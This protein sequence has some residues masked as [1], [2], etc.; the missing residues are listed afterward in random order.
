MLA[1]LLY[2][3]TLA[4]FGF[5]IVGAAQLPDS[6]WLVI[7]IFPVF[8]AIILGFVM[9]VYAYTEF[10]LTVGVASLLLPIVAAVL[11]RR[12]LSTPGLFV[13]ICSALVIGLICARLAFLAANIG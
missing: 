13:A 8:I 4:A 11:A 3:A 2:F 12:L 5:V 10:G 9:W 6:V 7:S 1:E